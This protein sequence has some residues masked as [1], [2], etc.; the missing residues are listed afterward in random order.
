MMRL[1]AMLLFASFNLL[2]ADA[3]LFKFKAGTDAFAQWKNVGRRGSISQLQTVIG[4]HTSSPFV[5]EALITMLKKNKK[6]DILSAS[7][8]ANRNSAH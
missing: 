2:G 8:G 1:C 7:F 3:I 6:E 5:R 4:N